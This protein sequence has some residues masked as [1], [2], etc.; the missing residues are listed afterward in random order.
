MTILNNSVQAAHFS[1]YMFASVLDTFCIASLCCVAKEFMTSK[2]MAVACSVLWQEA[3]MELYWK[4][5]LKKIL[6]M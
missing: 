4:V 3:V 1:A 2:K 6:T 5:L